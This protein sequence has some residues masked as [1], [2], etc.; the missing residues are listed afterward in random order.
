M[1]QHMHNRNV[2][3]IP[4]HTQW[5]IQG[6]TWTLTPPPF[7]EF[8]P[9]IPPPPEE[10]LDPP[11][12][13]LTVS[14]PMNARDHLISSSCPW[15]FYLRFVTISPSLRAKVTS[16]IARQFLEVPDR[17]DFGILSRIALIYHR[18]VFGLVVRGS[19]R[20]E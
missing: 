2:F 19:R 7:E 1:V 10:F 16:K 6:E 11:M 12:I 9:R 14:P 13:P 8:R 5:R 18:P 17:V 4:G 20:F 3:R 15:L